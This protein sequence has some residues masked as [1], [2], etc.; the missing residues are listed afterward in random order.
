MEQATSRNRL[1]V[2]MAQLKLLI[3]HRPIYARVSLAI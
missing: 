3:E 2:L 1:K